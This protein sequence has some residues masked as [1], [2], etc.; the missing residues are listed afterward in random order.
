MTD[1]E[2]HN[3]RVHI[4]HDPTNTNNFYQQTVK[5]LVGRYFERPS[6]IRKSSGEVSHHPGG[7]E[8]DGYKYNAAGEVVGNQVV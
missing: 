1:I 8:C 6:S 4:L 3:N 7:I 2:I 5:T